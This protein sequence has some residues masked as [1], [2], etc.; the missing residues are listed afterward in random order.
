MVMPM[1]ASVIMIVPMVAS[2]IMVVPMVASV[3]MVVPMV[4]SVIMVVPMIMCMLKLSLRHRSLA[5]ASSTRLTP[6]QSCRLSDLGKGDLIP[7]R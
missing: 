7:L 5:A 3:I 6:R 1:V 2:V 4:A